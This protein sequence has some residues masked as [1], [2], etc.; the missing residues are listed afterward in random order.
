MVKKLSIALLG[1]ALVARTTNAQPLEQLDANLRSLQASL[2]ALAN[3]LVGITPPPLPPRP[4]PITTP[5]VDEAIKKISPDSSEMQNFLKNVYVKKNNPPELYSYFVSSKALLLMPQIL[6]KTKISRN[7]TTYDNKNIKIDAYNLEHSTIDALFEKINEAKIGIDSKDIEAAF[8]FYADY[9]EYENTKKNN[10]LNRDVLKTARASAKAIFDKL[11]DG[12]AKT[13]LK[14]IFNQLD[15]DF[16]QFE[17]AEAIGKELSDSLKKKEFKEAIAQDAKNGF[18]KLYQSIINQLHVTGQKSI[19]F[20]DYFNTLR[21]KDKT[22]FIAMTLQFIQGALDKNKSSFW[23]LYEKF[24]GSNWN[25]FLKEIMDSLKTNLEKLLPPGPLLELPKEVKETFAAFSNTLAIAG[26]YQDPA[27]IFAILSNPSVKK[28]I[29]NYISAMPKIATPFT[30]ARKNKLEIALY[31]ISDKNKEAIEALKKTS[32]RVGNIFEMYFNILVELANIDIITQHIQTSNVLKPRV[33]KLY[34]EIKKLGKEIGDSSAVKSLS[35]STETMYNMYSIAD[36]FAEKVAK[37]INTIYND[38]QKK[39]INTLNDTIEDY[40]KNKLEY[41][42]A[43]GTVTQK[44][45]LAFFEELNKSEREVMM[46]VISDNILFETNT[47]VQEK[48]TERK[49]FIPNVVLETVQEKLETV[50]E[51]LETIID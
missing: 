34:D 18:E 36:A 15:I 24:F 13:E 29:N 43:P 51:K 3:G 48:E 40:L 23:N 47:W 5:E 38:Y 9:T 39:G 30:D 7:Y 32:M 22:A 1:I 44:E 33:K 50:Q 12:P 20:Q 10:A 45:P 41:T 28:V 16:T 2:Q 14:E 37:N 35:E 4:A 11:L 49:D 21:P 25:N 27:K 31:E 6:E 26:R 17:I 42:S 8:K 19:S 46:K